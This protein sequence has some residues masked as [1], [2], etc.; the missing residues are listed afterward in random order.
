MFALTIQLHTLDHFGTVLAH[1]RLLHFMLVSSQLQIYP[2][3]KLGNRFPK[4]SKQNRFELVYVILAIHAMQI[5]ALFNSTYVD[6]A[7]GIAEPVHR[8]FYDKLRQN[9]KS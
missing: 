4:S 1:I 5:L 9:L 7:P 3:I 8:W 6:G 2:N